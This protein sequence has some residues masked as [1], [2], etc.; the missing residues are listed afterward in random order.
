VS[1][2]ELKLSLSRIDNIIAAGSAFS[3]IKGGTIII[4]V[5]NSGKIKG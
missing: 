2:L 4:G 5:T 3:K 1:D